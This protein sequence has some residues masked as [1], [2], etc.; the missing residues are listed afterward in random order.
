M[1]RGQNHKCSIKRWL[2]LLGEIHF[3]LGASE[4]EAF[5]HCSILWLILVMSP[6]E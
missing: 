3:L 2:M 6:H 5:G 1:L 4:P